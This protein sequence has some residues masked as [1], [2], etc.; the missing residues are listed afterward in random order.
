[1]GI[2]DN[3]DEYG[4]SIIEGPCDDIIFGLK[5]KLNNKV[6]V[7]RKKSLS[8]SMIMLKNCLKNVDTENFDYNPPS[9]MGL[10]RKE[11]TV[12]YDIGSF[13]IHSEKSVY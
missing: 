10:K 4:N 9:F 13:M 1:M 6:K 7:R 12:S 11:S 2:R 8:K 3:K 5:K